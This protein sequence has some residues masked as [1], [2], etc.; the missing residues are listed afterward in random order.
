MEGCETMP[1][2]CFALLD[3]ECDGMTFKNLYDA[4]GDDVFRRIYGLVG[5]MQ[6]AE[7]IMQEV[8]LAVAKNIKFYHMKD[9][10]SA[11]AYILRIAK[12]HSITFYREKKKEK[13]RLCDADLELLY[14]GCDQETLLF[15]ICNKTDAAI[16]CECILSLDEI[17]S[18]VLNYYYLHGHTVKEIAK[19]FHLK[20][21][22]VRARLARGRVKLLKL[23]EGRN[24]N[25]G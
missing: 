15:D 4:Y 5:N 10:I 25:E 23:L 13:E 21:V 18:D 17:Y 19:L 24:L 7:D 11:R 8:W 16:I 14:D 12:N 3:D 9:G 1:L 2:V 22:T 20:E 6:D